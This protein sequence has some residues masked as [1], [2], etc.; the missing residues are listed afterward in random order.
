MLSSAGCRQQ[1]EGL[2]LIKVRGQQGRLDS[3]FTEA[4]LLEPCQQF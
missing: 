1:V 4:Y 3:I 2:V